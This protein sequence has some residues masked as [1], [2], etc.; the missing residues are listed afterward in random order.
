VR[1]IGPGVELTILDAKTHFMLWAIAEPMKPT[2]KK[3]T[4]NRNFDQ[5]LANLVNDMK[6]LAGGAS[7]QEPAPRL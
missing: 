5:A 7:K 6:G 4:W 2:A 3:A 1:L